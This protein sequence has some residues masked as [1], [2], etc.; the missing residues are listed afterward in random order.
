MTGPGPRRSVGAVV[1]VLVTLVWFALVGVLGAVAWWQ[2][3]PLPEAT[4][5]AQGAALT[6]VALTGEV[7]VDGWYVLVALVGGLLS[8]LVLMAWRRRDPLLMV[9]LVTAGAV[10]AALVT[11]RLG[12]VLGPADPE[13]VLSGRAEGAHAPIQLVLHATGAFWVWPLAAALGALVHLFVLR[14]D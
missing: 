11:S 12:R 3:T 5:T 1:D 7:A 8:A 14:R 2:L 9:V 6:A 13:Q 4:R 10:V